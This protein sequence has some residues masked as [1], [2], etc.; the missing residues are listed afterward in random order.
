MNGLVCWFSALVFCFISETSLIFCQQTTEN[1]FFCQLN[2][3]VKTFEKGLDKVT[4][5]LQEICLNHRLFQR[6]TEKM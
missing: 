4:V 1:V 6:N 3:D 2:R 5:N